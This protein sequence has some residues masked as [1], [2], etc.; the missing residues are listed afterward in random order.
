MNTT[1]NTPSARLRSW[2]GSRSQEW[3][4]RQLN[5]SLS[6]YRRWERGETEPAGVFRDAVE[7]VLAAHKAHTEAKRKE[8]RYVD[9][10]GNPH[11]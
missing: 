2:R 9:A 11:Y 1:P 3:A 10:D 6:T 4:A 7:R 5:V 8:P